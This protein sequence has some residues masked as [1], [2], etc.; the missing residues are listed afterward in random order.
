[1]KKIMK[2]PVTY[3]TLQK[4]CYPEIVNGNYCVS[5][6]KLSDVTFSVQD[7]I[8]NEAHKTIMCDGGEK[9]EDFFLNEEKNAVRCRI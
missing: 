1:M 8:N 9:I 7:D 5:D 3:V 4:N 2:I 6:P